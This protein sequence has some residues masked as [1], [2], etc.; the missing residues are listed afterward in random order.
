MNALSPPGQSDRPLN[1]DLRDAALAAVEVL[2]DLAADAL[3]MRS[4]PAYDPVS[5]PLHRA[6]RRGRGTPGVLPAPP[7]VAGQGPSSLAGPPGADRPSCLRLHSGADPRPRGVSV[8][9]V[10]RRVSPMAGRG[11]QARGRAPTEGQTQLGVSEGAAG[12]RQAL[13]THQGLA[14]RASQHCK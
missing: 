3:F 4:I 13:G 8:P 1:P 11:V 5:E 9:P 6:G 7:P 10:D 12:L 14:I 2:S